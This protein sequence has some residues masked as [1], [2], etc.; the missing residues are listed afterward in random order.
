MEGVW[1]C[2]L[3]L[4]FATTWAKGAKNWNVAM[5][6]KQSQV[7]SD[8]DCQR[9]VGFHD[10]VWTWS[11]LWLCIWRWPL[12]RSPFTNPGT[13][14]EAQRSAPLC[15]ETSDGASCTQKGHNLGFSFRLEASPE[16]ALL[17]D[18]TVSIHLWFWLWSQGSPRDSAAML[19]AW[20]LQD[21][22]FKTRVTI[23]YTKHRPWS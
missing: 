7:V 5:G 22:V 17:S 14:D 12:P 3:Y 21:G 18:F 10:F 13:Q 23:V 4:E 16:T 1:C 15:T 20:N 6:G 19:L 2:P 9:C 8:Q 11:S